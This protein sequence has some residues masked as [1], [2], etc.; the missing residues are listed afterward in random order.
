MKVQDGAEQTED[1]YDSE[2]SDAGLPPPVPVPKI[3]SNF[4]P[5]LSIGG[6]GLSTVSNV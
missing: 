5:K 2:D 3:K 1:S 4:I 6:L